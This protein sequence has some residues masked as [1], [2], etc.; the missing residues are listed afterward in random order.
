MLKQVSFTK[1]SVAYLG[2]PFHLTVKLEK[3]HCQMPLTCWGP[4]MQWKMCLTTRV[5]ASLSALTFYPP[6][7]CKGEVPTTWKTCLD[8]MIGKRSHPGKESSGGLGLYILEYRGTR[9]EGWGYWWELL[10]VQPAAHSPQPPE[11]PALVAAAQ[12]K[13]LP[14]CSGKVWSTTCW[15]QQGFPA[16]WWDADGDPAHRCCL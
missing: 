2:T 13:A 4:V 1:W 14:G 8:G 5:W 6:W 9:Q 11:Q 16:E 3:L 15:N 10:S 12:L 7:E